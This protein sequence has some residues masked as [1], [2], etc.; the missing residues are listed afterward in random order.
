MIMSLYFIE[1]LRRN[2]FQITQ[3]LKLNL[4]P[5]LSWKSI[6]WS[7][8]LIEKGSIWRI[9]SGKSVWIYKD[10]W[11]PS[12]EG[13]INSPVSHLALDSTVDSL[14]N[15]A[16]GWWNINLIDLC[17]YPFEAKL[18]KSLPLCS[19]PQP[20]TLV[21]RSEKLGSYSVKSG[22]KLLYELHTLDKNN[23]Q[24]SESQK[25][26][27]KSIWKL[28]VPGKIKHFLWKACTNSLPTKENLLK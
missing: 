23:P 27:W 14:I 26:F 6:L 16:T 12:P 15:S 13:R 22:Y 5:A 1:F 9:S 19:T 7:R 21:W 25:G 24:V 18:I 17:F 28:K 11:L 4:L 8:D 3:F 20:D 2:I 10:A